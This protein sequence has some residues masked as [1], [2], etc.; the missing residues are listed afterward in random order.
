MDREGNIADVGPFLGAELRR[1]M[2][3]VN[4]AKVD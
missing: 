4:A 2:Y 1:Y 3:P